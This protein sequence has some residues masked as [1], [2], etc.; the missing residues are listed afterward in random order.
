MFETVME[1]LTMDVL[2][3]PTLILFSVGSCIALAVLSKDELDDE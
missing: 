3:I 2:M 1:N